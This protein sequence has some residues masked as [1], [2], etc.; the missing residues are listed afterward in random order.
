MAREVLLVDQDLENARTKFVSRRFYFRL[1]LVWLFIGNGILV[2]LILLGNFL[3]FHFSGTKELPGFN[4]IAGGATLV[5]VL[6]SSVMVV[7]LRVELIELKSDC[8]KFELERSH[9][10]SDETP[11]ISSTF[12]RYVEDIT[13][14]LTEYRD[15]A[16]RYRA[17][18]NVFQLFIIVG[19]ILSTV[20]TTAAASNE[21][22]K[23]AAVGL[24][25]LV[26][27]SAGITSY[28]KF[29][30]RSVNLQQTADAIDQ[31]LQA[32][33]L[34][35]RRYKGKDSRSAEVE[36]AEEVERL[37]E[38]QRKREQQ[39]DQPPEV[40]PRSTAGAADAT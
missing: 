18:Q 3:F 29:R 12:R 8:R 26:S 19:S 16:A 23:W 6:F 33:A 10:S 31:E 7:S 22:F 9:I 21:S 20:A 13:I 38:D 36:F 35:I 2:A 40:S 25:A 11:E 39:L 32:L 15:G 14:Y 4:L 17:R 37:R 30:E 27:A 1:G 28:F 34:G 5:S 24:S